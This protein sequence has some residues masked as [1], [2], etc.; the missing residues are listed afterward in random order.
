MKKAL[1]YA[2]ASIFSLSA[3]SAFAADAPSADAAK[4]L[5]EAKCSVC[6]PTTRPLDKAKDRAGWEETV[7]RMQKKMPDNLN[8]ADAKTIIDYLTSIRGAK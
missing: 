6:H 5:F 1:I 3:V 7:K 8:D 2:A 4:A